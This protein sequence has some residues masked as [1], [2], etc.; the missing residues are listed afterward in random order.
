MFEVIMSLILIIAAEIGIPP[1]FALA[2]ALEENPTLN[3]LIIS[4]ANENGTVDL[5]VMQ[6]NSGFFGN[7]DWS[8]PETN[9]RA[10]CLLIKSLINTHELNTYWGVVVAYNCGYAR[11]LSQQGPPPTS[12]DYADRVMQRWLALEGRYISPVIRRSRSGGYKNER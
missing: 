3:P 8:D 12:L 7:I 2:I 11:F 5:G 10:G 6:L 1:Y 4:Q 9:I